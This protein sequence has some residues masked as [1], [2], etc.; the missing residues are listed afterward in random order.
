[1]E[2]SERAGSINEAANHANENIEI[3]IVAMMKKNCVQISSEV[4]RK[5]G[6]S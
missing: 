4:R 6:Y 1:M 2:A 5:T 3:A